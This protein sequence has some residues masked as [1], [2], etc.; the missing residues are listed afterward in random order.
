MTILQ[1]DPVAAARWAAS[2]YAAQATD[3]DRVLHDFL[4][5]FADALESEDGALIGL[6]V[7][8]VRYVIESLRA[9]AEHPD[10]YFI[11]CEGPMQ[12]GN[13]YMPG[14][15]LQLLNADEVSPPE[16]HR[17][18]RRKARENALRCKE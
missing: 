6:P 10:A 3:T 16:R 13:R 1:P 8:L 7:V 18:L 12:P 11:D 14:V 4:Q 9:V 17:E 2:L 15:V 5:R